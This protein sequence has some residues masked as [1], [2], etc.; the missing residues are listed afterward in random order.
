MITLTFR[1]SAGKDHSVTAAPG[2]SLMEAAV[3]NNIS[4]ID[5]SCGGACS[6]ATCMVYV[7]APWAARLPAKDDMED[8]MLVMAPELRETS[9]LSC[10]IRLGPEHEGLLVSMPERQS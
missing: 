10:Q 3:L 2:I 4:G 8:G 5:A 7:E 6:C 9:R 1:D